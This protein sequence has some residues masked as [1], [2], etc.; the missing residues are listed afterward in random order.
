MTGGRNSTAITK[1][2]LTGFSDFPELK[3]VL[4]VVFLGI[5][6]SA[7]VWK[8]GLIV[9]IRIDP[10]LHTPMYFFLSNLS[11]LDFWNIS[12]TAPKMLS[13]FSRKPKSILFM[14][15]AMQYFFSSL[16]LAECCLLAAMAYD[17][18]AALCNALLY[19]A[20]ISPSLCVQTVVGAYVTGLF[21]S[22]IQ[23][24]AIY[25]SSISA[26]QTLSTTSFVTCL[27]CW[28]SPALKL[29]PCKF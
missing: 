23:L 13:G 20:I 25:F 11:F 3:L 17:H 29:F 18:Y 26:D 22:L 24:C 10:H 14:G 15:C 8:L 4:F 27:S 12:S 5:Y 9:L 28:S 19:T 2:I 16:G 6:L 1:F 7:V 21:G